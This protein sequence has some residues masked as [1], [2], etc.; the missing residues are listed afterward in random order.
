VNI[1]HESLVDPSF[2]QVPPS[3]LRSRHSPAARFAFP[4]AF[5][6]IG[7]I[8]AVLLIGILRLNH[9]AFIYTLDDPYIHLA[10]S[11]QI[12][13]GNYGLSAGVH[14]APSS[15][16]LFPFLLA[17]ASGLAIHPYVPLVINILAL[18]FTVEVMRRFLLHLRLGE[19]N[20]ATV[21][22]AAF[23]V[24]MALCFNLIGVAF[25]GL[26]HSLHI[27][28]V[29]ASIYGLV[30]FLDR[31][32][33]PGWLPYV[34]VFSPA[35]RYEGAALSVGV[36]AVLALRGRPRTAL[37]TFGVI[38]LL[39][40]GFSLFL[41]KLG[42]PP[43]PSSILSK[44]AVAAGSV[45]GVRNNFLSG[46][47]LNF[48]LMA[49]DAIGMLLLLIGVPAACRVLQDLLATPRRWSSN[50]LMSLVLLFLIGGHAVAGRFGWLERYEDYVVVGVALIGIYIAQAAIR[51]S[52]AAEGRSRLVLVSGAAVALLVVGQ[53]YWLIT[54]KVPH[55]SNNI[56]EQQL[57]MH[58]FV[59]NF[60]RAPVAVNDLGLVSYRNPEFVLDLGG[61]GSE[62]SRLLK[63]HHANAAAYRAFVAEN[64]VHL[65]IVYQEW[66]P[67][68]IPE[69]W[70]RVGTL[71]LSRTPISAAYRDAQFYVTDSATASQVRNELAS[72]QKTLPPG[73]KLTI[74]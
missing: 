26:E 36:L 15:S 54:A 57:Q 25:T 21:T 48:N 59:N 30:L 45:S 53:R 16:I 43:L 34:L 47:L 32:I 19:D 40:G 58:N 74:F 65:V 50:G 37:V 61:L 56:Y 70:Q 2:P 49:S 10:L 13:H 66:F 3:K 24:L 4:L 22:Q 28:M 73:V 62:K 20:F 31:G 67:G 27:A 38:L 1:A 9:G 72:F 68:E 18:F 63:A 42:L 64:G 8:V 51:A 39:L 41:L 33:M 14:A 52:L 44:S 5:V 17:V 71:S 55:T 29:A 60:Y 6:A 12:R 11:D 35:L 23:L 46:I 69:D 7:G